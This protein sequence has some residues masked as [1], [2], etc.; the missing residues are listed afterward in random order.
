M[1]P[2]VIDINTYKG[3]IPEGHDLVI[4]ERDGE[5]YFEKNVTVLYGFDEVGLFDH[6]FKNP[7]YAF[8]KRSERS[9]DSLRTPYGEWTR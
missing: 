8:V 2:T 5:T 6:E 4:F 1:I 9:A 3:T 7:T